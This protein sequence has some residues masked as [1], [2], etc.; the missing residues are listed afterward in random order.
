VPGPFADLIDRC[1]RH[2]ADERPTAAEVAAELESS[3]VQPPPLAEGSGDYPVARPLLDEIAT[4]EVSAVTV[5]EA[6]SL[7]SVR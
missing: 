6:I 1:V 3:Y 7:G 2:Q 4:D 5:V